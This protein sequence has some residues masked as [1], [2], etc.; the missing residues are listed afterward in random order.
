M[1]ITNRN[2]SCRPYWYLCTS[3][4]LSRLLHI[5]NIHNMRQDKSN[6][7]DQRHEWNPQPQS[8]TSRKLKS[9]PAAQIGS[10]PFDRAFGYISVNSSIKQSFNFD[11]VVFVI[12]MSEQRY[13]QSLSARVCNSV[14][15]MKQSIPPPVPSNLR[16]GR[17]RERTT[18]GQHVQ[19]LP[20]TFIPTPLLLVPHG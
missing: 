4:P 8:P 20:N 18:Q 7:V 13:F 6:V 17:P 5:D 1:P 11:Q 19:S 9:Y 12:I 15:A 10:L 16:L 3:R 2:V 14:V